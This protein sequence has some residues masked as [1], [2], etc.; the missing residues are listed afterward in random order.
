MNNPN[1]QSVGL[2]STNH[3]ERKGVVC[4]AWLASVDRQRLS[5]NAAAAAKSLGVE[6]EYAEV[7]AGFERAR[8]ALVEHRP[9]PF[10]ASWADVCP[11]DEVLRTMT[12][13]MDAWRRSQHANTAVSQPGQPLPPT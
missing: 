7:M 5:I 1:E 2:L 11:P 4:S 13:E 12:P 9:N 10:Y 3:G 8:A 6:R